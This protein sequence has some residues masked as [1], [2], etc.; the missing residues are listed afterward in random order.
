MRRLFCILGLLLGS[1]VDPGPEPDRDLDGSPDASDCAPDD[2]TVHP[3][4]DDT[5]DGVD[6]DC[7]GEVDDGEGVARGLVYRD[8][9]HDG[10]GVAL[11]HD[12][13]GCARLGWV[14]ASEAPEL[15]CNDANV[16]VTPETPLLCDHDGDGAIGEVDCDDQDPAKRPGNPE[17]CN[18]FDDDCD[19]LVDDADTTPPFA[20]DRTIFVLDADDDGH[21]S[22]YVVACASPGPAYEAA[23]TI[24]ST[25]CAPDDPLVHPE[26]PDDCATQNDR[27]CDGAFEPVYVS[28]AYESGE[29]LAAI[30][31]AF[32][33]SAP[34]QAPTAISIGGDVNTTIA[35]CPG[36]Y[37]VNLAL[38]GWGY[39]ARYTVRGLG[40]TPDQVV[41]D[42]GGAGRVATVTRW[43]NLDQEGSTGASFENLTLA[44]GHSDASGGCIRADAS[45]SSGE[46]Y[47]E[48]DRVA[49]SGCTAERGG[50]VHVGAMERLTITATTFSSCSATSGGG[51]IAFDGRELAMTGGS[52]SGV[53]ASS[54][55]AIAAVLS[56]AATLTLTGVDLSAVSGDVAVTLGSTTY[57]RD[58]GAAA[59]LVCTTSGCTP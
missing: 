32:T 46:A 59:S 37:R 25:D 41:L 48:L 22:A 5:C 53:V 24:R 49:F 14:L 3:G 11:P 44:N 27:N 55:S 28:G 15:D 35:L 10:Y 47:L 20:A 38:G 16:D 19:G 29:A 23:D 40:T 39:A 31:A 4:A 18:G 7:D 57:G 8:A 21:P 58:L 12:P 36:T 1:C 6:T 45:A 51:G 54:G 56:G 43:L 30:R 9:D 34:G 17:R 50:A 42:A 52:F 2:P 33:A 13:I 26:Q